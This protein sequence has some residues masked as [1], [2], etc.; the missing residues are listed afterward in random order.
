MKDEIVEAMARAMDPG[1]FELLE[2]EHDPRKALAHRRHLAERS[3]KIAR[4]KAAAALKALDQAGYAV[5]PKEP[6]YAAIRAM[7]ESQAHGDEGPF[8]PLCDLIDFS[9]ENNTHIVLR[10]AYTAMLQAS[11]PNTPQEAGR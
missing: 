6:T 3:V 11:Q 9:G 2:V 1:E 7:S 4:D 8:P 5:V 10:A